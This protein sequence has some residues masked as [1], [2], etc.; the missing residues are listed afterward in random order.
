MAQS[1][2]RTPKT[3]GYFGVRLKALTERERTNTN[4]PLLV[5]YCLKEVEK[6]GKEKPLESDREKLTICSALGVILSQGS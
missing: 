6:R 5:S 1:A 3:K 4:V 2:I